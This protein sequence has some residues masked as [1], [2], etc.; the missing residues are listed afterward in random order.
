MGGRIK[1][2]LV[3]EILLE[4]VKKNKLLGSITLFYLIYQIGLKRNQVDEIISYLIINGGVEEEWK[5][6]AIE[7]ISRKGGLKMS[8]IGEK[9]LLGCE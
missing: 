1:K 2:D 5:D 8:E 7:R 3:V 9:F 6:L 4:V